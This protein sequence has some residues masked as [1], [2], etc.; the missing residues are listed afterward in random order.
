MQNINKINGLHSFILYY[1]YSN[2]R[3][4]G[5]SQIYIPQN[6]SSEYGCPH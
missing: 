3:L 1:F 4:K 6:Y 5:T 2:T